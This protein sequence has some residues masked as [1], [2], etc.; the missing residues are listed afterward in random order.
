MDLE[1]ALEVANGAMFSQFGRHLNDVETAIFRGAWQDQT[2]EQIA[3]ESGYSVRY[4]KGDVGAKL[5]KNLGKALGEPVSKTNFRSALER[6]RE[7]QTPYKPLDLGESQR[8][9]QEAIQSSLAPVP[10]PLHCDWGEAID[11]SLFFGRTEELKTLKQWAIGDRCRLVAILGLGGIGKT[12]LSVKLAH[13]LAGE[14]QCIIWRSLR[15][16]PPLETLLTDLVPFLSEQQDT[17]ASLSRLLHWLRQNR[18]LVVLDNMETILQAGDRAGRFRPGY[19]PYDE[20]L[21]LLGESL[22]QSCVLLTSREK[23]AEVAILEGDAL[24]IRSLQIT[25]S[26]PMAEALIQAKGL[27]GTPEQQQ[28]LCHRY[29]CSPLALK[30]VATIIQDLF[31]GEIAEFL[32]QNAAVF[33]DIRRLLDQQ[34]NRLTALEQT[35]MYWLAINR[36]WTSIAELL[37]DIVPRVS[38]LSLLESLESLR[39]RSLI[40]KNSSQYT[41]QPVVMEYVIDQLSQK[42]TAELFNQDVQLFHYYALLKTTTKDYITET[43]G[44]LILEPIAA[45]LRAACRTEAVLIEKI[46]KVLQSLHQSSSLFTGYAAGNLINLS[47]QLQLDLTGY[48]FSQLYLQHACL[49]NLML[50]QVN[51]QN[52][53]FEKSS[54]TQTFSSTLSVAFCPTDANRFATGD[55]NGNLRLWN[56]DGHP[57]RIISAHMGWITCVTWSNDGQRLASSSTDQTVK[58]WDAAT[59]ECLQTCKGSGNLV[60]SVAFSPDQSMLA[61]GGDDQT[62]RIWDAQSGECLKILIG[63]ENVVWAVQFNPKDGRL[64]SASADQTI[65]LWDARAGE[66]LDIWRG[67]SNSVRTIAWSPD[68]KLLASSSFDRTIRLWDGQTGHCLKSLQGHSDSVWSVAWSPEGM[69]DTGQ[70]LATGSWDRTVRLWQ[71]ETGRCLKI[72][73]GHQNLIWSVAWSQDGRTVVTSSDDETI[74]LW[75][76][77]SGQCFNSLQGYSNPVPAVGWS[78][79]GQVVVSG[80]DDR[81]VRFWRVDTGDCIRILRGHRD[82]IRCL[83][84][85]PQQPLLA[86]GSADQTVRLWQTETGECLHLL[87]GHGNAVRSLSWSPDGKLLAVSS[88]TRQLKL[89]D[90][91]T[92]RSVMTWEINQARILSVAYSPD[93]TQIALGNDDHSIHLWDAR[94]RQSVKVLRGHTNWVLCVAWSP[95][96]KRLV[97]SSDDHTVRLWDVAT[98]ACIQTLTDHCNWVWSVGWSSDSQYLASSSDDRAIRIHH[99]E[100]GETQQLLT[101]H[102]NLIRSIAWS[103]DGKTL[104]SSSHDE[105]VK[106]WHPQTGE[107]L[108]TLQSDRPYEGMNITGVTGL[109]EAQ[110]ATL[111]TLGALEVEKNAT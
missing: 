101:G 10:T 6:N 69:Q 65:R 105:T 59:G 110:K 82:S 12:A 11:V 83:A 41:Q 73:Q 74:K 35:I 37:E 60:R 38:R 76:F 9:W 30:I 56:T 81:L 14:F 87:A 97:S 21:K 15:N 18:C 106:L 72:L 8:L 5:W 45:S 20:L 108:R 40:E 48:D 13:E 7:Q 67:H 47:K 91:A 51:F 32:E 28:E 25:G 79:D 2:Y 68:G 85:H 93:G 31:D 90:A 89:W 84:W 104:A 80:S 4:I 33:D 17:D 58:V 98:A 78:R 39:W 3:Q 86:S 71:V 52:A 102:Q 53:V 50:R 42:I 75:D 49:K 43:Q 62:V 26:L 96:G 44:R 16:A 109:T 94:T 88:G 70:L 99:P 66:C 27:T 22:H 34:F 95:D 111:K 107:C 19:E 61:S 46:Q 63:H 24:P 36:Q 77:N 57:L 29:G 23:P 55:M 54:F 103:P 92:G 1:S 64:V 100:S